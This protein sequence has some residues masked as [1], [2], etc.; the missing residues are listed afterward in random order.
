MACS[1]YT[2]VW[3][4]TAGELIGLDG[5]RGTTLRVTRGTLWVTL[6]RDT[7]DVVLSAGDTFTIDRG[8]L[9]LIEAQDRHDRVRA[10]ASDRHGARAPRRADAGAARCAPGSRPSP[11]RRCSAAWRR[12]SDHRGV[13]AWR[14]P[15]CPFARRRGRAMR[16]YGAG[17]CVTLATRGHGRT[18]FRQRPG[19]DAAR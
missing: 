11:R 13:C 19:A 3:E 15:G 16:T 9:T 4:L 12:T 10:G 8:G 17:S 18:T 6:E 14:R 2:K 1:G 5:A 7:R